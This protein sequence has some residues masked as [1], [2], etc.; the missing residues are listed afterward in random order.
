MEEDRG[1]EKM[2]Q[3]RMDQRTLS[4]E[5]LQQLVDLSRKDGVELRNIL[6]KGQPHPDVV[7]GSFDV[8]RD[9]T[10]SLV[11]DLLSQEIRF[12]LELFP[13]GTPF[14]EI[15]RIDFGS[16]GFNQM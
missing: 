5:Q 14:P 15:V 6:I 2:M 9:N 16:R 4:R 1:S 13:L 10:A 11:Q 3:G 8:N 12:R 7:F